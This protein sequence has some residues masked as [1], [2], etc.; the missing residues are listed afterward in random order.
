MVTENQIVEDSAVEEFLE[1]GEVCREALGLETEMDLDLAFILLF[2][3]RNR[4]A[5]VL[6]KGVVPAFV[7][8]RK[9]RKHRMIGKTELPK[10]TS[11]GFKDIVLVFAAGMPASL[12]MRMVIA[13]KH[14]LTIV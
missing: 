11:D 1:V 7:R 3:C 13:G 9:I 6:E 8:L 4:V 5:I 2:Q 12:G 10:A 14:K